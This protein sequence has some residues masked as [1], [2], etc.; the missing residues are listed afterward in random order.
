MKN[1]RE[2]LHMGKRLNLSHFIPCNLGRR[3]TET[4]PG[5]DTE[6][7]AARSLCR[8]IYLQRCRDQ[9]VGKWLWTVARGSGAAP[10]SQQT[11]GNFS[12]ASPSLLRKRNA[13]WSHATLN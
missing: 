10:A 13:R 7:P 5:H 9:L 2:P 6:L 12:P 1:A 11:L 3:T 4:T 8:T